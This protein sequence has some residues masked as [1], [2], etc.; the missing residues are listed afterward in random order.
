[1]GGVKVQLLSGPFAGKQMYEPDGATPLELLESFIRHRWNWRLYR[2]QDADPAEIQEWLQADLLA[3]V[4]WALLDGR[5]IRFAGH[6]WKSRPNDK[7]DSRRV[8]EQ[9]TEQLAKASHFNVF[10][11]DP[12]GDLVISYT[13]P[14]RSQGD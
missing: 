12:D 10:S 2:L 5:G 7:E 3:R 14:P 9:V 8:L 11:D 13:R 4:M 1:M 6:R